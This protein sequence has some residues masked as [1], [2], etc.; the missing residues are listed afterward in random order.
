[1][2]GAGST[3]RSWGW[4]TILP[5]AAE[6]VAPELYRASGRMRAVVVA[7]MLAMNL[8][9]ATKLPGGDIGARWRV[10]MAT[11]VPLWVLDGGIGLLMWRVPLST[12][13]LRGLTFLCAT[14]E[15]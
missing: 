5:N 14:L 10:H 15:T 13:T 2:R 12:R 8:L 11:T 1:M 9:A 3:N 4:R 7:I 6:P